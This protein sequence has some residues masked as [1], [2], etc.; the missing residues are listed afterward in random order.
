MFGAT[1]RQRLDRYSRQDGECIV[2]TGRRNYHGYGQIQI[3]GR[4]IG[5][6]RAAFEASN[7]PIPDGLVV[8]HT[9][10][11]PPCI[12]PDHLLIGTVA[13]NNRDKAERGRAPLVGIA[14][15]SHEARLA[16]LAAEAETYA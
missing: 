12:N 7:G 4:A 15:A 3:A 14:K 5:A 13:D 9:C 8:R 2:W 1:V 11:N 6:H 16:R 10:D